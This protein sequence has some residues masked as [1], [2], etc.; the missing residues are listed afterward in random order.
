[1]TANVDQ[2]LTALQQREGGYVNNPADKGG[3]TNFGITEQVARAFGFRGDMRS[4]PRDMALDIYRKRYWSRPHFDEVGMRYPRL[5]EKLLDCGVNMGPK[6]AARF[7]QV[8]LNAL[9]RQA[10]QYPD[11]DLDGDLGEMSFEALD[12]YH[13]VRGADGETVLLRAVDALQGA[14]Y[15][16]L[17]QTR[18][19]N[20]E[21]IY[22][23]LLN[24]IGIVT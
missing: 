7:L 12:S 15:I 5:A 24:R 14:R 21:F 17:T 9:N 10:R 1:M 16:E 4:L 22:G 23:W 20:E 6:V 8:A 19:A 13:A 18:P 11:V 2:L 3:P